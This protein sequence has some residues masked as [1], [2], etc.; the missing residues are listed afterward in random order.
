MQHYHVFDHRHN[1]ILTGTYP[2]FAWAL[3]RACV[4][5]SKWDAPVGSYRPQLCEK[6]GCE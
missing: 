4:L 5:T 2:T 3:A 6:E 1:F